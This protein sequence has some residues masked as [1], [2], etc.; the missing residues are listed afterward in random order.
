MRGSISKRAASRVA[1]RPR[2][3]SASPSDGVDMELV[4]RLAES[5]GSVDGG[6]AGVSM[7]RVDGGGWWVG[8]TGRVVFGEGGWLAGWRD[9]F[10]ACA[11]AA[12][13]TRRDGMWERE[14]EE[15]GSVE[16][17]L[18]DVTARGLVVERGE[19]RAHAPD[20]ERAPLASSAAGELGE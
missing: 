11:G 15:G 1:E 6:R 3:S 2:R 14:E 20:S 9:G 10:L 5:A 19:E 18:G 12:G 4:E 13:G 8:W 7:I 17:N 16:S